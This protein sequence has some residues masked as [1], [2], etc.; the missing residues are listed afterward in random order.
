MIEE[1]LTPP[2]K[3]I[4]SVYIAGKI[5]GLDAQ[6][7]SIKFANAASELLGIKC[8]P[9]NPHPYVVKNKLD[10]QPYN[11]IMK[12]CIKH[13]IT[14]D[15]VFMLPD[16]RE[17]KGATIEHEVAKMLEIPIFYDISKINS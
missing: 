13:L 6:A 3:Q 2:V 11:E 10:L 14:C 5:T 17:S 16:W 9:F 8:Y 12:I 15:A 1:T 4:A 7:T